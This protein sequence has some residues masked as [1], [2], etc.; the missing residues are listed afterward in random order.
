LL[1]LE[2][3]IEKF[4]KEVKNT[5]LRIDKNS[6]ATIEEVKWGE[7]RK[8]I[9]EII[10][11]LKEEA[12]RI[13]NSSKMKEINEA[14]E[15]RCQYFQNNQRKMIDSLTNN[16]KKSIQINR[17]MITMEQDKYIETEPKEVN[18]EVEKY[19]TKVF[20]RR[21]TDFER[22]DKSWKK[23]YEPRSYIEQEWYKDLMIKPLTAELT[24]IIKD[25][26]TR[27]AAGPSQ[28]TYEM[29]INLSTKTK[30]RLNNIFVV[31]R[32]Q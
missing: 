26:P 22:L 23:Q 20:K 7:K 10:T 28:I 8:E 1:K 19:F 11:V 31:I 14:V 2:E 27:K 32:Q 21:K 17:I 6:L 30:E 9:K 25:L 15:Q 16:P 4:N 12:Y 13:Q 24:E 5:I 18:K 3:I 29:L